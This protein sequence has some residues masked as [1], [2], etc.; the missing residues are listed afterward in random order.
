MS[1][2]RSFFTGW[3]FRTARPTFRP[4]QHV[5]VYLTGFDNER[6][7]GL[8]RI[9]DSLLT[10]T[11]V[12]PEQVDTVVPLHIDDFDETTHTGTA[13]KITDTNAIS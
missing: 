10:V 12:T 3:Q 7:I 2:W 11:G 1:A 13:Q 8:A 5:D 4:G 6:G 9:G